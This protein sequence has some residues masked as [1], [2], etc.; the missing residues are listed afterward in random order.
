M[1][2]EE[3]VSLAMKM[4]RKTANVVMKASNDMAK[5]NGVKVR[6]PTWQ[7]QKYFLVRGCR[8]GHL[9]TNTHRN[10]VC[11]LMEEVS[12]NMLKS[13]P[14]GIKSDRTDSDDRDR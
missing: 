11:S 13:N 8:R 9:E 10:T 12:V 7:Q 14:T 6:G 3:D 4:E 1:M 5:E 2:K